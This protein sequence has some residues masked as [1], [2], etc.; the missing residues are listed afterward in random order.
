[1]SLSLRHWL[2]CRRLVPQLC[3]RSRRFL[4]TNAFP[5]APSES[6]S[7]KILPFGTNAALRSKYLNPFGDIR[8]GLL[9][10]DLDAL[11]GTVAYQHALDNASI[12]KS[13]GSQ[14]LIIKP[15]D[16]TPFKPFE[17]DLIIVTASCNRIE[18]F[19]RLRSDRSLEMEGFL[20]WVGKSSM[21]ILIQVDSIDEQF[22][23]Q[24]IMEASFTMVA[25]NRK[26]QPVKVNELKPHTPEEI[27]LFE[28]GANNSLL[29]KQEA[30]VS[31]DNK[32]PTDEEMQLIHG[33]FISMKRL[34]VLDIEAE[35]DSNYVF[36][37]KTVL[38]STILMQP[39]QRNIHGK[40]F[41]GYLMLL[42]Y[43]LAWSTAYCYA[44]VPPTLRAIDSIHFLAPVEIGDIVIFTSE[45]VF[46]CSTSS[47][48]L[49][50]TASAAVASIS[51]VDLTREMRIE[52]PS[53]FPPTKFP[54]IEVNVEAKVI[55]PQ[56][57]KHRTTNIFH[58]TFEFPS[59]TKLKQVIPYT[60]YEAMRFI[61]GRREISKVR[62]VGK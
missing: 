29:R 54:S 51:N 7:K 35:K 33:L 32:P 6:K 47:E 62:P 4:S 8:F 39:Q 20:T 59:T 18:L 22:Q 12:S 16:S 30:K 42:A 5:K 1:M 49:F 9:L 50:Q 21:E 23:H 48:L 55:S 41:G 27:S 28:Q 44:K 2:A 25:R 52:V 14:E 31:L 11:A 34:G 57:G 19:N 24:R 10:E 43:E 56:T 60:Y 13:S 46:S 45:V 15:E 40:I 53:L 36:M 17:S 61:E 37:R 26:D 38:Q 3:N 58:F